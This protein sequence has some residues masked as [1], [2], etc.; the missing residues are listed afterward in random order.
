MNSINF[1]KNK[2]IKDLKCFIKKNWQDDHILCS[3]SSILEFQHKGKEKYNFVISR[4]KKNIINGVLGFIPNNHFDQ[5]LN[6]AN[7]IWLALWKVDEELASPGLGLSLL[8]YLENETNPDIIC[9]VGLNKDVKKIYEVL[10]YHT[11][12]M[13]HFYFLN[14]A[15]QSYKI[16]KNFPE[17][18]NNNSHPN[19]LKNVSLKEIDF[20][21]IDEDLFD[22]LEYKSKSYFFNRYALHPVYNYLVLGI[23]HNKK[24]E[25]VFIARKVD[26]ADSSCL[27]IIDIIGNIKCGM[28]LSGVLSNLLDNYNCEYIDCLNSGIEEK[29]FKELGFSLKNNQTII[30]EYFEPFVRKN[31]DIYLA[32]RP[33][34]NN[35]IIYKGD[36]DQDRPNE[37]R[38]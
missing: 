6:K 1:C 9:V 26:T 5:K 27:R 16:I 38:N 25:V 18:I 22:S 15:C 2:D 29:Y 14:N 11:D 21:D 19:D 28:N 17:N 37:I 10:G 33:K 4:N 34:I 13:N 30:P 8:K 23:F 12:K 36:G 3:D 7:L 31:I 20:D 24:I 35:F 32:Y